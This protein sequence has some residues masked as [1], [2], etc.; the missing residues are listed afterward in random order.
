LYLFS[1]IK[2][3]SNGF[4]WLMMTSFLSACKEFWGVW[5][6][7]NWIAYFRLRWAEFKK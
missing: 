4:T 2:E 5:I 1:T 3:N 7:K 6:N